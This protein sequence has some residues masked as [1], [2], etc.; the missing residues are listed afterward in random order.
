MVKRN[1][2]NYISLP[3]L[4]D[5]GVGNSDAKLN[6]KNGEV[7]VRSDSIVFSARPEYE[8]YDIE[9]DFV[10]ISDLRA[11]FESSPDGGITF[12]N[13]DGVEDLQHRYYNPVRAD[14]EDV[15]DF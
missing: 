13:K 11:A 6:P 9:S 7:I 8:D 14:V 2:Y 1:G 3:M 10:M 12:P 15:V 4:P 5:W